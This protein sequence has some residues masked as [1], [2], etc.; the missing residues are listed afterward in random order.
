MSD[1]FF[2]VS[3]VLGSQGPFG[4]SG[5]PVPRK[6]GRVILSNLSR[7]GSEGGVQPSAGLKYVAEGVEIYR[8]GGKTYP[9]TAGNFLYVPE[10]S[11]G[12][13][14]I[15]RSEAAN[16][17]G[18]CVYLPD[19]PTS[20][21][22]ADLDLPMIFPAACS[23]LGRLLGGT[24]KK[25]VRDKGQRSAIASELLGRIVQD[26]EP[27]LEQTARIVDGI[28]A[29]KVATRYETLRRL[30]VAR[31]YL[32]AVTDRQ[33]ELA[34]LAKVAGVSRFQLLR[35]FRDA[36]GAPPAAYHRMLRL[37]QIGRAHV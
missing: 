19:R 16:T 36:F 17:L 7:G 23:E 8:Y 26:V 35:S 27:L 34:E 5:K 18:L 33:V 29:L 24:V 13:V 31:G 30:N 3:G 4:I 20:P 37:K 6:E 25:M 28:N 1:Q 11:R 32:H 22:A 2:E 14:E 12:D 10:G 9:V 15:G 21:Q